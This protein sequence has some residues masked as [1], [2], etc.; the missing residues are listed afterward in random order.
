M[1]SLSRVVSVHKPLLGLI[2]SIFNKL[3]LS[4]DPSAEEQERCV[5]VLVNIYHMECEEEY[6]GTSKG[7]RVHALFKEIMLQ[8]IILCRDWFEMNE[9]VLVLKKDLGFFL[10]QEE[11]LTSQEQLFNLKTTDLY[12]ESSRHTFRAISQHFRL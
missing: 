8:Y 1:L 5:P 11:F 12:L 6:C 2:V 10:R 9:Q 7:P 3:C 4:D